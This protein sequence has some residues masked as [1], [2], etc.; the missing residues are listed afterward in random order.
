M[1][2]GLTGA[3]RIAQGNEPVAQAVSRC[4]VRW[5]RVSGLAPVVHRAG[6]VHPLTTIGKDLGRCPQLPPPV[7]LWPPAP[8][9]E[10]KELPHQGMER[11]ERPI[12]VLRIEQVGAHQ[13]RQGILPVAVD[14]LGGVGRTG[15]DTALDQLPGDR[16]RQG[17]AEQAGELLRLRAHGVPT[18][19]HGRHHP[20]LHQ[21]LR[22]VVAEG[23]RLQLRL[24]QILQQVACAQGRHALEAGSEQHQ[25]EGQ[26]IHRLHQPPGLLQLLFDSPAAPFSGANLEQ[27]QGIGAGQHRHLH[28][29]GALQRQGPLGQHEPKPAGQACGQSPLHR[30][31][32][33]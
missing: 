24:R 20:G 14:G 1:C 9:L 18:G 15:W 3:F 6:Q 30:H 13:L 2:K 26:A 23:G 31:P 33:P 32:F 7:G 17:E 19:E 11:I 28:L 16:R 5:I 10:G 25:G 22:V 4:R 8:A 21:Q 27:L 29:G 12:G